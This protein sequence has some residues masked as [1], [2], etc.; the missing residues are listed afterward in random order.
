M[1]RLIRHLLLLSFLMIAWHSQAQIVNIE[2]KRVSRK[3]TSGIFGRVVL[4]FNLIDNGSD[5]ISGNL[6]VRLD[7][8]IKNHLF[9]TISELNLIKAEGKDLV[10]DGFQHFRY[11]YHL[12][13][14]W[15][16][17]AFTQLQYNERL[18]VRLRGLLGTGIR[19]ELIKREKNRAYYGLSYMFDYEE[20]KDP[21]LFFRDH[22]ISTYLSFFLQ[23]RDNVKVSGTTYFQPAINDLNDRRLSTETSLIIDITKRLRLSTTFNLLNDSRPAKGIQKTIYN[24]RNSLRWIF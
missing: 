7:W 22:R 17:E 5:I 8:L 24:F 23:L 6:S 2:D 11:N 15:T 20:E 4:G 10:N 16:Y 21:E 14:R 18:R 12:T 1:N 19:Y 13:N 3:D 9:I